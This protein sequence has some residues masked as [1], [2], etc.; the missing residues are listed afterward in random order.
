MAEPSPKLLRCAIYTRK[1]SEEGLDQAFNSLHAQREACEAFICSQQHEGWTLVDAAYDDGA[2]S[3]G[4][5][6]RPA[7]Q[8][9]LADVK[10]GKIDVIVVY[11]VD[12]LTRSLPDFARIVD[13]LDGAKASFVS[14]T[15]AFNTTTSMGRLT[16]NVLL[17]FAQFEREVTGE[18]IRDKIAASKAKGMWMGG[19]TPLGYDAVGREL[20][21]NAEEAE[22]VRTVFGLFLKLKSVDRVKV[23]TERLGLKTKTRPRGGATIGGQ[24]FSR[25]TLYHLLENRLYVGEVTHRDKTYPGR[26][27]PIVEASVFAKA[28]AVIASNRHGR[29]QRTNAKSPSLLAGILVDGGGER[30][31]PTHT[32]RTGRRYRYYAAPPDAE[33]KV[34]YRMPA[35]ALESVAISRL[36]SFLTSP[37]QIVATLTAPTAEAIKEAIAAAQA[38]ANA[39]AGGAPGQQRCKIS[40]M[41][42]SATYDGEALRLDLHPSPLGEQVQ[43]KSVVLDCPMRVRKRGNDLKLVVIDG[44]KSA[45]DQVL[46]KLLA[47]ATSWFEEFSSGRIGTMA[48]LA[49]REGVSPAYVSQVIELAFLSPSIKSDILAGTQPPHVSAAFLKSLCP[50]PS[51]WDEQNRLIQ[52]GMSS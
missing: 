37:D 49:T 13:V 28:Q 5:M 8:A 52:R 16:L 20:V 30:F 44:G 36:H 1:S 17:S 10:A 43:C 22:T 23:K 7:L 40:E 47:K 31:T 24:P 48:E 26:H 15:Q 38:A 42:A 46:I 32:Q 6:Q 41:V 4:N 45:P 34:P 19:P 29:K 35:A 14:V 51:D 2:Y 50:L 9:I 39:L 25:G 18:R 11:K 27:E 12:R 33:G 3:G 21:I